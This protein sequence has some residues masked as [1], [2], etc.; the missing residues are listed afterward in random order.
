VRARRGRAF[1]L[2]EVMVSGVLF[3]VGVA[4]VFSSYATAVRILAHNHHMTRAISLAEATLEE[5]V[6]TFSSSGM[7]TIGSHAAQRRYDEAGRL[8]PAGLY[9]VG[10]DVRAFKV[11]EVREVEVHVRWTEERQPRSIQLKTWRY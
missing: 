1:S 7:L 10:W 9:E 8:D 2:I 6:Y 11:D 5:L 4:A 3:L